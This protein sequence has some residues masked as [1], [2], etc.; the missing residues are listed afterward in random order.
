MTPRHHVPALLVTALLGVAACSNGESPPPPKPPAT[1]HTVWKPAGPVNVILILIDTLRADAVLDPAGR[2]D[3]PNIDRLVSEGVAFPRAF[4]AAPMTLPS[5]VSLFSSR[6]PFETKVLN[7]GQDVPKSLPL[8]ADW[9]KGHG[10]DSRAVISLGTLNPPSKGPGVSRGFESYDYDYW[11]MAQAESTHSR[12]LASLDKRDASDPLFLF[13]H[14]SDPHE[15]YNAHGTEHTEV[16]VRMDGE[17]LDRFPISDMAFWQ[18]SVLL[19][20]GRTVFEFSVPENE[21]GRFRI[22]LFQGSENG[23]PLDVDF[24]DYKLMSRVK[25][26]VLAVDRGSRAA[27]TCD[28][29]AW[30]NDVP[31]TDDSRRSR[32]AQEVAYVDHYVGELLKDLEARGLYEDSL[33]VFTSDHG[34]SLG[35]PRNPNGGATFGHAEQ[36]TDEQIHVPL[37]IRLPRNDP[38]RAELEAAAQHV[39]SQLDLTPTLLEIIG[40]DPLPGQRG[41]SLFE[42]HQSMHVAQTMRPEAKADQVALRDAHYKMIF[43]PGEDESRPDRFELYDLEQDPGEV[44]NVFQSQGDVRPEWP[45]RLRKLYQQSGGEYEEGNSLDDREAQQSSLD[46][47]GYGGDDEE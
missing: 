12:L 17:P 35:E 22:R 43:F 28:L 44:K 25:N 19:S 40:V 9:L 33:I 39:V 23:K 29:R 6:Q 36:L 45:A 11:C 37:V 32:Y 4:S 41:V 16:E 34:E 38:R 47:L 30:I 5:H 15:P 3:T 13:A 14:Y 31:P 24:M 26:A 1:T 27:A 7:N 42:P 46:A 18:K 8:L 21:F 10:Y 20:E 2:Y